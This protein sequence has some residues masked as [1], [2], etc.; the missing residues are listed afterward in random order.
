MAY[1]PD[2]SD[3]RYHPRGSR[4]NTKSVG[5]LSR[6]HAFETGTPSQQHLTLLLDFCSVRTVQMRGIH[7][8]ELC[9]NPEPDHFMVHHNGAT[10]KLGSAEIRVFG[11][12]GTI[13]AAPDL[14]Y[15]YV[16]DHRYR[17]PESFLT[18]L[19][20]SPKPPSQ[21]FFDLLRN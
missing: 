19:T 8:C 2:M 18:A 7:L 15:H 14:I 9:Q 6:Q 11:N 12:D 5:W 1:F 3:Y 16:R 20:T 10:L 17:P 13:Y 4:P 21:E